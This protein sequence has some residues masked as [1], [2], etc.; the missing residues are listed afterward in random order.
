L[1]KDS[2]LEN[3]NLNPKEEAVIILA[4]LKPMGNASTRNTYRAKKLN[5]V[6]ES[7]V[8][9]LKILKQSMK[10]PA[11][12]RHLAGQ[13]G[14][15]AGNSKEGDSGAVPGEAPPSQLRP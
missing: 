1:R 9:A 6:N 5:D 13:T 10:R 14:G 3:S 8:N 2:D 4:S 7:T 11:A 15:G 12:D